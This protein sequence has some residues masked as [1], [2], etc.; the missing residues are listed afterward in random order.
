M[1]F[2]STRDLHIIIMDLSK[3]SLSSPVSAYG[4]SLVH[5]VGVP[6]ND[7]VELIGHPSRPGHIGDTEGRGTYITWALSVLL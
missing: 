2:F 1:K 4:H 6:G 7:V 3:H 5:A